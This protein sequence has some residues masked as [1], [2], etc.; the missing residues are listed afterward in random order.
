MEILLKDDRQDLK[1]KKNSKYHSILGYWLKMGS[2]LPE[3]KFPHDDYSLA[4]SKW[5]YR[6]SPFAKLT[7]AQISLA[8]KLPNS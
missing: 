6:L 4:Y 5:L 8:H 2:G 1:K 3:A 7:L